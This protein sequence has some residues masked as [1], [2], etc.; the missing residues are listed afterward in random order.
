MRKL[1]EGYP[2][3]IEAVFYLSTAT[4]TE[5]QKA[6][7]VLKAFLAAYGASADL[8]PLLVLDLSSESGSDAFSLPQP[9]TA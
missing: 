1:I 8:I 6:R 4:A 9:E 3:S 5:Q 2:Y 7:D